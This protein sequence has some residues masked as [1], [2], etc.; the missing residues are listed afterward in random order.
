MTKIE[1]IEKM[2]LGV[3]IRHV[4]FSDVEWMTFDGGRIMTEEGYY[5][6]PDI[7]WKMDRDT[8][9]WDDGY[10]EFKDRK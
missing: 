3:K 2:R 10:S 6:D 4:T 8:P 7:F 1:A 9:L 5:H